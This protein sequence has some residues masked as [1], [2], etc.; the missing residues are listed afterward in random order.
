MRRKGTPSR[1]LFGKLRSNSVR[2]RAFASVVGGLRLTKRSRVRRMSVGDKSGEALLSSFNSVPMVDADGEDIGAGSAAIAHAAKLSEAGAPLASLLDLAQVPRIQM[3]GGGAR[4]RVS[5]DI[6]G[7]ALRLATSD[8]HGGLDAHASLDIRAVD[9]CDSAPVRPCAAEAA[10]HT[11]LLAALVGASDDELR[12]IGARFAQTLKKSAPLEWQHTL[13]AGRVD[14]QDAATAR[15]RAVRRAR[16]SAASDIGDGADDER[17]CMQQQLAAA[18]RRTLCRSR[19]PPEGK[20]ALPPGISRR[21]GLRSSSAVLLNEA[22]KAGVSLMGSSMVSIAEAGGTAE[23]SSGASTATGSHG[24][25][26]TLSKM[27]SGVFGEGNTRRKLRKAFGRPRSTKG[28][29]LFQKHNAGGD[30]AETEGR[31]ASVAESRRTEPTRHAVPLLFKNVAGKALTL[32]PFCT[33]CAIVGVPTSGA[34]SAAAAEREV[35]EASFLRDFGSTLSSTASSVRPLVLFSV[36]TTV[37]GARGERWLEVSAIDGVPISG[38]WLSDREWVAASAG[39]GAQLA[40]EGAPRAAVVETANSG[41]SSA[42]FGIAP[43]DAEARELRMLCVRKHIA[44]Q[45]DAALGICIGDAIAVRCIANLRRG[46]D[47]WQQSVKALSALFALGQDDDADDASSG[48]GGKAC[49]P[50]AV[51]PALASAGGGLDALACAGNLSTANRATRWDVLLSAALKGTLRAAPA[52]ISGGEAAEGGAEESKEG[53]ASTARVELFGKAISDPSLVC[54][55]VELAVDEVHRCAE[56]AADGG[57]ASELERSSALAELIRA[58]K[59]V[60]ALVKSPNTKKENALLLCQVGA[61]W[62]AVLG[63][64]LS[65]LYGASEERAAAAPPQ[66]A[67]L[68]WT[69]EIFAMT[70]MASAASPANCSAQAV[71]KRSSRKLL[72]APA[73]EDS[74]VPSMDESLGAAL[75]ALRG[76]GGWTAECARVVAFVL[77]ALVGALAKARWGMLDRDGSEW[78]ALRAVA[79][80]VVHF[81]LQRPTVASECAA[82]LASPQSPSLLLPPATID[83]GSEGAAGSECTGGVPSAM[84]PLLFENAAVSAAT[85]ASGKRDEPASFPHISRCTA[86]ESRQAGRT[87]R[88]P[89]SFLLFA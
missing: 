38:G 52:S 67:L 48:G 87:A 78:G 47:L 43:D 56:A 30:A 39:S 29:S 71:A 51:H 2:K 44:D 8:G 77:Q 5:R 50:F 85:A 73:T 19:A 86:A 53:G 22:R 66:T 79:T 27:T 72:G 6:V 80:A 45:H 10:V 62:F 25:S 82:A 58:M 4:R 21:T 70:L 75:D 24:A 7:E 54:A 26:S 13:L 9:E 15:G 35:V 20:E 60:L 31:R 57:A 65:L 11:R 83:G 34:C 1:T 41:P 12:A 33:G 81:A 37:I 3:A 16:R 61:R 63:A 23:A 68:K 18:L 64:V 46:G 88:G 76:V 42:S 40:A 14:A 89:C 59:G 69:I 74:R 36:R 84:L 55:A 17:G 32:E 49:S 28:A